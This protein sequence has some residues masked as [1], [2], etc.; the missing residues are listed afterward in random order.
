MNVIIAFLV[1]SAPF[2]LA[3]LLTWASHR[4]DTVRA[5]LLNEYGDPDHYRLWH[6][7]DAARTR[8]ENHPSWPAS[9]ATGERR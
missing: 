3:A 7:A 8:F 4:N 6:D 9:G 2:V 1:L 5:G